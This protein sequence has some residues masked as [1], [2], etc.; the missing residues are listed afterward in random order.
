LVTPFANLLYS[1]QLD[2]K[3]KTSNRIMVSIIKQLTYANTIDL[4]YDNVLQKVLFF[5]IKNIKKRFYLRLVLNHIE[6]NVNL[7]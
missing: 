4:F 2:I 1:E 7:L 6:I 5:L 3:F